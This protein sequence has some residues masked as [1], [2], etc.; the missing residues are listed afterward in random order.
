MHAGLEH[1]TTTSA[2]SLETEQGPAPCVQGLAAGRSHADAAQVTALL[3]HA[4]TVRQAKAKKTA[5]TAAAAAVAVCGEVDGVQQR[6][7]HVLDC[8]CGATVC[9]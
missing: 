9:G 3:Q 6:S 8:V 5:G 7:A 2:R 4:E 1:T